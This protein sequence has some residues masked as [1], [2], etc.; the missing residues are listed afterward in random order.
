MS[1]IRIHELAIGYL[2]RYTVYA[3]TSIYGAVDR[4]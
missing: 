2:N 1:N 3:S 4:L